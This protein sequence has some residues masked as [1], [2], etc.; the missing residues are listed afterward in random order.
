M[1]WTHDADSEREDNFFF[2]LSP[3]TTK[4]TMGKGKLLFKGDKTKKKKK[5]SKHSIKEVETDHGASVTAPMH[6]TVPN[7]PS[8]KK[9]ST[10]SSSVPTLKKGTGQITSSGTV[11]T[12]HDTIFEKEVSAG[13]ALM[14]IVDGREELRVITMRLSNQSL[15]LSSA[16]SESI[17]TPQSFQYIRKPRDIAKEQRDALK[18]Q[19]ETKQN[20]QQHAFDLYSAGSLVYREK[21]ETGSYRIKR[22]QADGASSRGDLLRMRAKK[23]SDK[24]C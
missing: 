20:L 2:S 11:V 10:E 23:T 16:F 17:K 14:C 18:K 12:G 1:R 13:D 3:F 9:S 5:K 15:N 6:L 22:E 24:Y 19:R 4:Q 8:I 7:K 21:T